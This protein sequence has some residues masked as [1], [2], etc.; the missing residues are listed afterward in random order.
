MKTSQKII[1]IVL[2]ALSI[3]AVVIFSVFN[4]KLSADDTTNVLLTDVIQR[5][6]LS[7][8]LVMVM[9]CSPEFSRLLVPTKPNKGYLLIIPCIFV[10]LANFPFFALI[11]GTAQ[12]NR[13]DLLWLFLLQC[14]FVGTIEE[15]FF[16]AI[17][18][19][20]VFDKLQ[21]KS[22]FL[23]VIVSSA[24]FGLWHLVNLF[25]GGGIG[26]TLLQVGY[27]FLIGAMLSGLMLVTN[28]IWLAVVVHALFDVGGTI[29]TYL[30]VGNFQDLGFWILTCA[31]GFICFVCV[32]ITLIRLDKQQNAKNKS[33]GL[34]N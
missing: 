7:A 16:R 27:S 22:I 19:K 2:A 24:I 10:A 26:A 33:E 23:K 5:A 29:V 34:P 32:L 9:L 12:I 8:F 20:I 13:I 31:C 3:G 15:L 11:K 18:Q 30:G 4:V 28:N 17:L 21:G 1:L 6:I 14:L 25:F